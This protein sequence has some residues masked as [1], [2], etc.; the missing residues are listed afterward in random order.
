MF[1][2]RE[3]SI[4]S[5]VGPSG[6]KRQRREITSENDLPNYYL[7]EGGFPFQTITLSCKSLQKRQRALRNRERV[8]I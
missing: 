3:V 5:H 4:K 8:I 6:T 7:Y 2:V 1:L